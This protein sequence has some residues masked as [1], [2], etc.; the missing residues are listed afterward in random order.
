MRRRDQNLPLEE[1]GKQ[2]RRLMTWID[3]KEV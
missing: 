3:S 1:V 2:L